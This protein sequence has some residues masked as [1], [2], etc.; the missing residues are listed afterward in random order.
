MRTS[1][2]VLAAL[3]AVISTVSA[4]TL[5]EKYVR[6]SEAIEAEYEAEAKATEAGY[7]KE[8]DEIEAH[9]D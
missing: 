5:E 3:F 9:Y 6:E 1:T 4:E 7:K 2:L 8:S